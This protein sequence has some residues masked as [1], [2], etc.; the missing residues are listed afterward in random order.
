MKLEYTLTEDDFLH[1]NLF[2]M[3]NSKTAAKALTMQRMIGPIIFLACS[4]LFSTFGDV[5]FA[6][7][8]T[9]FLIMS[10]IWFI[11]YPKY[12]F[13][14]IKRHTLKMIREGKNEGLL[15]KH[16][17]TMNDDSLVET[18][19]VNETKVSWSGIQDFK[20]DDEF[21]YLYNSS[22]SAY[23]IPKRAIEQPA[24]V[25]RYIEGKLAR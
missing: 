2:H 10:V 23:I 15:G 11:F 8:F 1:F 20:E 18:T 24:E 17:L 4:Y 25:K 14:F 7:L 3:K 6:V 13:N 9:I 19:P 22:I 5:P 21:F 16:V 12:Y